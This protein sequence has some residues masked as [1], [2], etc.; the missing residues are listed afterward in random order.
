M[1]TEFE[2]LEDGV[3]DGAVYA[4]DFGPGMPML[5]KG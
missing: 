2:A 4:F 5:C 3:L 1:A